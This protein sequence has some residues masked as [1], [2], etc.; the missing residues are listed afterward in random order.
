[1]GILSVL[2]EAYGL[3]TP[4]RFSMEEQCR[5]DQLSHD[6]IGPR[7][8]SRYLRRIR[9]GVYVPVTSILKYNNGRK[10]LLRAEERSRRRLLNPHHAKRQRGYTHTGAV[11]AL[12]AVAGLSCLPYTHEEEPDSLDT[13]IPITTFDVGTSRENIQLYRDLEM[14]ERTEPIFPQIDLELNRVR[15]T[16]MSQAV[17]DIGH[18][19]IGMRS[20][21]GDLSGGAGLP[22]PSW[23]VEVRS[24]LQSVAGWPGPDK[25]FAL[26]VLIATN[27]L[28]R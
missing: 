8:I 27:S 22:D 21:I 18:Q 20:R 19:Y 7:R 6:G 17:S 13:T 25:G 3:L 16:G 1:M 4:P 24:A 15:G 2:S 14:L 12:G 10:R 9:G 28:R 5:I 26:G 11:L 23:Y